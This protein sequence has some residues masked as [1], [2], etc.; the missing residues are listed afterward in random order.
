MKMSISSKIY[1]VLFGAVLALLLL[2]CDP[3]AGETEDLRKQGPK[4]IP[5]YEVKFNS[6]GGTDIPGQTVKL[7]EPVNLPGNDPTRVGYS[8]LGWYKDPDPES[9]DLWLFAE[10]KVTKP[11]T[12]YA[13]WDSGTAK[14]AVFYY[15][16]NGSNP[17]PVPPVIVSPP[18]T[19]TMPAAPSQLKTGH[20]FGG[21]LQE[22]SGE[23]LAP[24]EVFAA[25]R[26]VTF[27][28]KWLPIGY[29]VDYIANGGT[30]SQMETSEHAFNERKKLTK[31]TYTRT[32]YTF[33]GWSKGSEY[34]SGGEYFND[35]STENLTSTESDT[36]ILYA[37]WA[38]TPVIVSKPNSSGPDDLAVS[39]DTS[40][41][42]SPSILSYQWQR[43]GVNIAS[44]VPG[45]DRYAPGTT[46]WNQNMS[47]RVSVKDLSPTVSSDIPVRPLATQ[48]HLQA[49]NASTPDPDKTGNYILLDNVTI[50]GT[51]TPIAQG[52]SRYFRGTFN[53]NG[54]TI[55]FN[56]PGFSLINTLNGYNC[57]LFSVIGEEGTVKNLKLKGNMT[58]TST[59]TSLLAG[60]VAGTNIGLIK[61]VVS[62]V[63]ITMTNN[64]FSGVIVGGIAG[65]DNGSS[66]KIENCYSTGTV[67]GITTNNNS[68][69]NVYS[70][71]IMGTLAVGSIRNCW[72]SSNISNELAGSSVY[73]FS[74]GIAGWV[75]NTNPR[76]INCVALNTIITSNQSG[77]YSYVG[78]VGG[79]PSGT[80][81]LNNY[82]NSSLTYL[83]NRSVDPG[84]NNCDGA[85][86]GTGTG[87]GQAGDQAWWTITTNWRTSAVTP[88]SSPW[89]VHTTK[90]GASES[91]PWVWGTAANRLPGDTTR[92]A[93][94]PVLWFE[95][96]D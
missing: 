33:M 24:G 78:R 65:N 90:A 95:V 57:G 62:E 15:L 49:I 31:C 8:F 32:G 86:V 20:N 82:A 85:N 79:S 29:T 74:G 70:G 64:S 39:I 22:N 4:F 25:T 50:T 91:S 23:V 35:E 67:N 30:G 72:S 54:K 21:W 3:L 41:T 55:E 7:G 76:I 26:T 46:D 53:G 18:Y 92:V 77:S 60:A 84:L 63:N 1:F 87:A 16:G 58:Y 66:P 56:N 83:V 48:A 34:G 93:D 27:Y 81:Y 42:I 14:R 96:N 73:N 5:S 10:D 69:C 59:Y 52:A 47:V 6:M 51:W 19:T 75:P 37:M 11:I 2:S 43:N 44:P 38:A 80:H 12:L 88:T 13:R 71:G 36:V 61:N 17:D 68:N 28:V 45:S 9:T 89:T 94:R 40:N